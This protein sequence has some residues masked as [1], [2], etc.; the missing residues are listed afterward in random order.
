MTGTGRP[1][2]E[3]DLHAYVD[4]RLDADRRA[5]VERYLHANPE[6]AERVAAYATQRQ[7]L[8]T[9]L[10]ARAYDLLPPSLNLSRLL[11]EKLRRRRRPWRATAAVLLALGLGAGAGWVV[12]QRSPTGVDEIAR[13]A[14]MS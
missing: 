8:R 11:E 2:A 10:S 3:E 1:I 5:A 12:G 13:E 6:T 7:V 9:A 14:A 4:E